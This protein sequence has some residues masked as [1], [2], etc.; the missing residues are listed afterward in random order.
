MAAGSDKFSREVTRAFQELLGEYVIDLHG[1]STSEGSPCVPSDP[2][3]TVEIDHD[4]ERGRIE[5][6]L[7]KPC[8]CGRN[9]QSQF[10]QGEVFEARAGFRFLTK[11]EQHCFI[12]AQ[13]RSAAR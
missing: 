12:L 6:F 3:E 5:E 7:R 4:K 9:C 10:E 13:M 1:S 11:G 2:D 8:P